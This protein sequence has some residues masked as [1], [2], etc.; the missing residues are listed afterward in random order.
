MGP[1]PPPGRAQFLMLGWCF[2][3]SSLGVLQLW[4]M[5]LLRVGC[6]LSVDGGA[7]S[8]AAGAASGVHPST[9]TLRTWGEGGGALFIVKVLIGRPF[10]RSPSLCETRPC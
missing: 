3:L 6:S 1:V 4:D 5:C 2:L 8:S 10:T 7:F 9:T